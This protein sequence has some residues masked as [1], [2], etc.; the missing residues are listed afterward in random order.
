MCSEVSTGSFSTK[1]LK[2]TLNSTGTYTAV[3]SEHYRPSEDY[4]TKYNAADFDK[5]GNAA[6]LSVDNKSSTNDM[7]IL[8]RQEKGK[9]PSGGSITRNRNI[10]IFHASRNASDQTEIEQNFFFKAIESAFAPAGAPEGSATSYQNCQ[11]E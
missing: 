4:K 6:E 2:L 8:R 7:L 11:F 5:D 10:Q 3:V 9:S 1:S